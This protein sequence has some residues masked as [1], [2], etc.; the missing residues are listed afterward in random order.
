M[1]ENINPEDLKNAI[2][3]LALD[4]LASLYEIALEED[5]NMPKE[6]KEYIQFIIDYCR[7][8]IQLMGGNLGSHN[9]P[10]PQWRNSQ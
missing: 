9:I 3:I 4:N 6:E 7:D 1:E 10:R 2:I 5:P 8:L